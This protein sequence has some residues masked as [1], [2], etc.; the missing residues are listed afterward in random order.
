MGRGLV[1]T[2]GRPITPTGIS[3]AI[4]KLLRSTYSSQFGSFIVIGI[5][6]S[7]GSAV[8]P[9]VV[10]SS[11]STVS[12]R[13]TLRSEAGEFLPDPTSFLLIFLGGNAGLSMPSLLVLVRGWEAEEGVISRDGTVMVRVPAPRIM[14]YIWRIFCAAELAFVC[15]W[16][17]F[18]VSNKCLDPARRARYQ[19]LWNAT[20]ESLRLSD[21][22]EKWHAE[23]EG[24]KQ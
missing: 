7:G 23:T 16:N 17:A 10:G 2:R 3:G 11:G 9:L 6:R 13:A 14:I 8:G 1:L 20:V 12:E 19:I 18:S 24:Q 4:K 5:G 21:C 22:S 15:G